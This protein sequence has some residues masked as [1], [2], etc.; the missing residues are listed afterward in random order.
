[1]PES[2][3]LRIVSM[4]GLLA[5]AV[6]LSA[7]VLV[8]DRSDTLRPAPT[9]ELYRIGWTKD[10]QSFV[11]DD[12]KIGAEG[13]VWIINAIRTWVVLEA[14]SGHPRFPGDLY[15]KIT[16]YGGIASDPAADNPGRNPECACHAPVA[17]KTADLPRGGSSAQTS[18]ISLAYVDEAHNGSDR[19]TFD[20][21]QID[22]RNLRW[23]VPGGVNIQ[24]GVKGVGRELPGLKTPLWFNAAYPTQENHRLRI[25][26]ETGMLKSFFDVD[27]QV[28]DN[29]TG[30]GINIK[31]WAH[32]MA[33]VVVHPR[34]AV[35]EVILHGGA[36]FDVNQVDLRNLRFGPN[37][38]VPATM[39]RLDVDGDGYLDLLLAFRVEDSGVPPRSISA[40]L[41]GLRLDNIPFEG[42]DLAK[43]ANQH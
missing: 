42:C 26:D 29:S 15:E 4:A 38:A 18:D 14:D 43:A 6:S 34:N 33:K 37:D 5:F 27:G 39:N 40:C 11:G 10:H 25:F 23:S 31:V 8:L 30:L 21:W 19:K 22:F 35:F 9:S 3:I 7:Q 36:T 17:L 13:E 12:F 41:N 2:L 20:L 28:Q 1:M 24:F 32:R 16:L